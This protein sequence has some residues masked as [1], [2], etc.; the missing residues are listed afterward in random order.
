MHSPVF[1]FVEIEIVH[2]WPCRRDAV[3]RCK[4]C[5]PREC[6][7]GS[8]CGSGVEQGGE[9]CLSSSGRRRPS[10]HCGSGLLPPLWRFF[11]K[12]AYDLSD[13][14]CV[15]VGRLVNACSQATQVCTAKAHSACTSRRSCSVEVSAPV[16]HGCVWRGPGFG[17]MCMGAVSAPPRGHRRRWL[18]LARGLAGR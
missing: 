2:G 8:V 10:Q 12:A 11:S 14:A 6:T 9:F 4:Q 17:H 7:H 16:L 3:Q 18:Q 1:G 13:R 5:S 15:E